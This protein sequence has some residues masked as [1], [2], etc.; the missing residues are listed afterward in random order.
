MPITSH[1]G[2]SLSDR[3]NRDPRYATVNDWSVHYWVG[4]TFRITLLASQDYRVCMPPVTS[5]TREVFTLMRLARK[6]VSEHTRMVAFKTN[7][8]CK[9]TL[10]RPTPPLKLNAK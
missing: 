9:K 1:K 3:D 6:L 5:V 4:E 10:Q 2:G 8:L 7:G